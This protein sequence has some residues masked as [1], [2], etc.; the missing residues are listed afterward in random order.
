[1]AVGEEDLKAFLSKVMEVERR[2]AT[3]QKNATSKRRG[4]VRE[5][6][7]NWAER[8]AAVEAKEAEG[9]A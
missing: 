2:Y 3:D 1:M 8:F 9:A 6:V 4:E 7:E 5:L